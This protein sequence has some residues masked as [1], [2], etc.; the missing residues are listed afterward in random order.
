MLVQI[1]CKYCD[2]RYTKNAYSTIHYEECCP[3]CGD[4]H[5]MIK[6]L[7]DHSVNYYSGS[8]PFEDEV[9]AFEFDDEFE[10]E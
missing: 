5:V 3:K 8:P 1:T 2:Y 4:S 6:K 9:E 7:E 10:L